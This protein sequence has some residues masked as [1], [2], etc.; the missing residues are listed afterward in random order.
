MT[1]LVKNTMDKKQVIMVAIVVLLIICAATSAYFFIGLE[2]EE[3]KDNRTGV[4]VTI[5]S[6]QEF[7]EK[8]GGDRVHVTVMVPPGAS[9]HTYE[10]TPGMMK[11][12]TKAEMYAKVGSGVEFENNWMEKI[13]SNNR[14]MNIVDCS[15]GIT[16]MEN[17]P[18]IWNSPV[19]AKIMVENI[20]NGLIKIDPDNTDYY[21]QNKNNYLKELDTLDEYIHHKLDGFSNRVFMIYHP[22]FGYLA[23]EYNL[24]QLAVEHGGKEPTPQVIQDCIDMAN[25][26]N[27]QYV[28]VAPQFAAEPC[29]TVARAIGGETA[30]MD[31]LARNYISNMEQIADS[32]ASEFEE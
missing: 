5:V 13:I 26:Y 27:L 12:V 9:P 23:E 10:P 24:T 14:D 32:L 30:S 3:N 4:I 11:E 31:P 19:N 18:H 6:Q 7:V 8:V 2:E 16:K 1:F 29:K 28:F 20:C 25:Q 17:D 15:K 22:S 21:T